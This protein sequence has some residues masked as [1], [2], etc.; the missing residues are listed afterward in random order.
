MST[1]EIPLFIDGP[2]GP[3]E[4]LHLDTPDAVGVALIC[5][6]HPLFAGTMQNKVVATLQRIARDA[7]YATL[8][9]NFRG[10]GQSAG[11]YADGRGEIDDAL[12]AARWLGE[13]HP[14]LPLTPM[15][16]SFGSCVAGNAAARL[17][18]QGVAL[19]HLFM[20]APPVERF[21][22]E[23]PRQCPIT[24]VQPE[25]DEVVTPARVY[26]WSESLSLPHELLRV[27]G[28]SH[29]FHGKLIELKDLLQPRLAPAGAAG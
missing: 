26:A 20:L 9:F 8:R 19:R 18:G 2:D 17:E 14:G 7:G 3:L 16:F 4:A 29:F 21:A 24:V 22:V 10:V 15:G 13:K 28:C 12:A 5:H 25:D 11:S 23:L 27:P 6:P 1:R